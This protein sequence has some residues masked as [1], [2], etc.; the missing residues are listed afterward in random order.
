MVQVLNALPA[1]A[2]PAGFSRRTLRA[3]RM[4]LEPQN[5]IQWWQHLNFIMR[6]AVCGAALAGLLFG[7]V[8]G[9]SLAA[10]DTDSP[11]TSYHALYAGTGIFP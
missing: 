5:L 1:M 9:T 8:M 4:G 2:A 7:A 3:F 10:P 6:G 11:I